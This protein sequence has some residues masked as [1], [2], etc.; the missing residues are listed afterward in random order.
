VEIAPLKRL[1]KVSHRF[2]QIHCLIGGVTWSSTNGR[3]K[4]ISP[5][6]NSHR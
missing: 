2:W 1:I 4:T 6:A 3:H 5:S